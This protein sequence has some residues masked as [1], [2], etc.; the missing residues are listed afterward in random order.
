MAD[1]KETGRP[2]KFDEGQL[3]IIEKLCRLGATDA[4]LAEALEVSE[5]T[6][7]KWKLD[8]PIFSESLKKN[9]ALANAL[10][11]QALFKRAT[12]SRVKEDKVF[13]QQGEIIVHEGFKEYPPDVAACIS[14]L[15]NRDGDRWKKDGAQS[16]SNNDTPVGKIQIEVVGA[17]INDK[18]DTTTS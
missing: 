14:W 12:G 3:K 9:K 15:S 2:T 6:I 18:A 1:K 10:V 16:E 5:S 13:N 11:E 4:D 7:N 8:F 17:N